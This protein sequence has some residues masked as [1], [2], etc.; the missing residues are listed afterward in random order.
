MMNLFPRFTQEQEAIGE[1]GQSLVLTPRLCNI[2]T[3]AG[4]RE[5]RAIRDG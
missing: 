5:D 3:G 2:A 4:G 1:E